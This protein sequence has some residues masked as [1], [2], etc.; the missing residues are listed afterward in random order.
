MSEDDRPERDVLAIVGLGLPIR[1]FESGECL[2][3]SDRQFASDGLR[4][5]AIGGQATNLNVAVRD[6]VA[7]ILQADVSLR[8]FAEAGHRGE[9]ALGDAIV[10]V[11]ASDFE[12]LVAEAIHLD[13]ALL[14]ADADVKLVPLAS[15]T[16]GVRN[17][18]GEEVGTGLIELI[19]PAGQLG[20]VPLDVVLDLD[21]GSAMPGSA[22][23]FGD[24]EHDPGV[25]LRSDL[26]VDQEFEVVVLF[27]GHDVASTLVGPGQSPIDNLPAIADLV[28]FVV[29]PARG[30]LPIEQRG[31]ADLGIPLRNRIVRSHQSSRPEHQARQ[32]GETQHRKTQHGNPQHKGSE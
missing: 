15:G 20:V 12:P 6:H 16:G 1:P 2:L 5:F 26:V 7:V 17:L 25:P 31:P 30:G 9:L 29:P 23:V 22:A 28:L 13:F 18:P 11:F 14:L 10:P 4:G 19:E 27:D 21:F 24:T 3:D 8:R 32:P